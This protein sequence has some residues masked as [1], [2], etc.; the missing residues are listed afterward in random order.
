[1]VAYSITELDMDPSLLFKVIHPFNRPNL[2][3][4]VCR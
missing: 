1:M 3:Y 4:E 2:F